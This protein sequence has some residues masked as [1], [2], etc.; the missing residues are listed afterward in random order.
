MRRFGV[1]VGHLEKYQIGKLL[2]VVAIAHP[3]IAQG[4][5]EAPDFGDDGSGVHVAG[6]FLNH[7]IA[8]VGAKKLRRRLIAVE[9][10][11]DDDRGG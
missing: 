5:A 11:D 3:V 10:V 1:L 4:G 7:A 2:Q 8:A 9:V 6:F